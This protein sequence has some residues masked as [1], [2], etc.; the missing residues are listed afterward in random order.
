MNRPQLFKRTPNE[1]D[2]DDF[3]TYECTFKFKVPR[4]NKVD[5]P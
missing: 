3:E 4:E 2:D 5:R 1:D